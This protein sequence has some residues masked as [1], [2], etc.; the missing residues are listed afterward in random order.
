MALASTYVCVCISIAPLPVHYYSEALPTKTMS[1]IIKNRVG[2]NKPKRHRQLR[3]K[4]LPKV[5]TQRLEWDTNLRPS[6]DKAPNVPLRHH[7]PQYDSLD[8][9]LYN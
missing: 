9:K 2:V 5:P 1:V 6:G 4:D 7:A 3:V 8:E